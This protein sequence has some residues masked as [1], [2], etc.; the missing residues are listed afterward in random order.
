MSY[1]TIIHLLKL[2]NSKV[3]LKFRGIWAQ[4]YGVTNLCQL[5][6]F[7]AFHY[8]CVKEKNSFDGVDGITNT[9]RGN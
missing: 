5:F 4:Q 6:I 9:K 8:E 2:V 7:L 1:F 3:I